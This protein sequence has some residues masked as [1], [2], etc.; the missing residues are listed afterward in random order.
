M[1][2]TSVIF[3]ANAAGAPNAGDVTEAF[4]VID[5]ASRAFLWAAAVFIL[6]VVFATSATAHGGHEA[7]AARA[8]T[9]VAA[10]IAVDAA[11][12]GA[13]KIPTDLAG[14]HDADCKS[15]CCVG[16]LCCPAAGAE[17][18]APALEC[19]RMPAQTAHPSPTSVGVIVDGPRRPPKRA[20]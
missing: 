3:D 11:A 9:A 20:V 12:E 6:L 8:H 17:S 10:S 5:A 19:R 1:R 15:H 16:S 13:G 18:G 2:L 14:S 7:A 4:G